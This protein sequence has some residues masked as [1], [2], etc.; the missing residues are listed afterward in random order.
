MSG[1][2]SGGRE[3]G[4]PSTSSSSCSARSRDARSGS[5]RFRGRIQVDIATLIGRQAPV[6]T[7]DGL[8]A[9]GR[10]Q[11]LLDNAAQFADVV[12]PE[13]LDAFV[14]HRPAF[15]TQER[16][17]IGRIPIP[18]MRRRAFDHAADHPW[19][20]IRHARQ[21]PVGRPGVSHDSAGPPLRN[22]QP[23]A[24]RVHGLASP[25]RAQTCPEATSLRI[26][27]SRAWSATSV[28]SRRCSCSSACN[29]WPGPDPSRRTSP[30]SGRTSAR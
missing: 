12:A 19:F 25:G 1:A 21:M 18:P 10:R 14:M 23:R 2:R 8:L 27:L 22:A 3:G 30:A 20:V 17:V 5:G 9:G 6:L 13:A 7:P 16:P 26:A 29:P 24:D 28:F 4:H 15:P 11:P